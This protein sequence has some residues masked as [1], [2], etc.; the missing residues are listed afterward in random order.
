MIL[1]TTTF[2]ATVDC[3]SYSGHLVGTLTRCTTAQGRMFLHRIPR[4]KTEERAARWH[5]PHMTNESCQ[6]APS[7]SATW[8]HQPLWVVAVPPSP[9]HALHIALLFHQW[10]LFP[11]GDWK[12][13]SQTVTPRHPSGCL[14][15]RGLQRRI[16]GWLHLRRQIGVA[17]KVTRKVRC[18]SPMAWIFAC[19]RAIASHSFQRCKVL[20]VYGTR[21]ST[22]PIPRSTHLIGLGRGKPIIIYQF[23]RFDKV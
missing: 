19:G 10:V 8:L 22:R 21:R 7:I 11:E 15:Y 6:P 23:D 18:W 2:P 9:H 4:S 14:L 1:A 20:R 16:S 17:C 5:M 12:T 3:S 13:S